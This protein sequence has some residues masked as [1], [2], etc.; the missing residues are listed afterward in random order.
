MGVDCV[1]VRGGIGPGYTLDRSR[2]NSFLDSSSPSLQRQ[3]EYVRIPAQPTRTMQ[4][5]LEDATGAS[6]GP[7]RSGFLM[8]ARQ[9]TLPAKDTTD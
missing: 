1:S 6:Q 8:C 9:S 4:A 3:R 2:I 5:H 7:F